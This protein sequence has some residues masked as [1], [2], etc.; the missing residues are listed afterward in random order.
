M[1]ASRLGNLA[2][3]RDV[4][5]AVSEGKLALGDVSP[6]DVNEAVVQVNL[7][8]KGPRDSAKA[9]DVLGVTPA[10]VVPAAVGV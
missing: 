7:L 3:P 5:G 6:F 10:G 1:R 9:P 8:A 2:D 4:P